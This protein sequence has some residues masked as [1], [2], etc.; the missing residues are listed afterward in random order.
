VSST[1]LLEIAAQTVGAAL[2]AERGG[3]HRIELCADLA[4]DGLTPGEELMRLVR[5]QVRLPIFA[6]IRP[7]AGDFAYS[8]AEFERMRRDIAIAKRLGM[9]GVVFGLL[10]N[11]RG[12]D[13]QPAK[14]L[15]QQAQ[16]L[17]V[18]FHRA[19]DAC[20]N[21]TESLED[22]IETGATRILTSGGASSADKGAGVLAI[23]IAAARERIAIL[24]GGGINAANIVSVAEQTGA[25]EFHSGLGSVLAYGDE[26]YAA[27]ENG[28]RELAAQL[29]TA[30]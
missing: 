26:D 2:A 8:T 12:I 13:V 3:A 21:L 20:A 19:F 22:V 24:P 10:T 17:P 18:T 6:M 28:V 29:A 15:I 27:F 25:R 23:L 9:N 16:P 1:Y 11:D 14:E 4:V 5:A 30:G 7:R